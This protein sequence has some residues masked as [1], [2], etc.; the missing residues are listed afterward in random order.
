MNKISQKVVMLLPIP[1]FLITLCIG[2][3]YIPVSKV[4]DLILY[5]I[6]G[7][8]IFNSIIDMNSLSVLFD[9]RLPRVILSML[10]GASLSVAGTSFQAVLK[11]PL[12]EPYTLGLSSGAAF[13]AALAL[14]FLNIPVQISAFFFAFISV[15]ICYLVA[16][17]DGE[18]S[19]V[20]LILSGV[21]ISSSFTAFLSVLQI[22]IDPMKLQGLIYWIMGSL[23]TSSWEKIYS[24]LPYMLLGFILT[25]IFRWKLNILALGEKDSTILGVNPQKYK[26]I[27]I[28]A[29]TLLASSAVSVSGIISLVGLMIPHILRMLFGPD[30]RKMIPMSF[31]LGASYLAIIDCFSRNLCS[32]EIPIGIL[33]TI[34]GAPYF[35]VLIRKMKAGGWQ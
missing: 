33:T 4:V 32:F 15:A 26:I 21:V 34:I 25:F 22:M 14:S 19:V 3:Y 18:T 8:T 31:C 17:K 27:F 5:K 23:H 29:S 24:V 35:I 16:T 30:N 11:N 12:A 9:I 2:S 1:V 13:G 6:S 7:Y 20:S 10:V 28:F